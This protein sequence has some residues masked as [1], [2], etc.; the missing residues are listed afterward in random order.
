MRKLT[1]TLKNMYWFPVLCQGMCQEQRQWGLDTGL[2]LKFSVNNWSFLYTH[3]H[4][5]RVTWM[6]VRKPFY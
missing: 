5:H 4:T 2:Q 6:A 3:T 1:N